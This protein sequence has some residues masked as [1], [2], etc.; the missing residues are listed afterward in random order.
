MLPFVYCVSFFFKNSLIAYS[1]VS[2]F[3]MVMSVVSIIAN[4]LTRIF[5][6]SR[7]VA[8]EGG[9]AEKALRQQNLRFIGNSYD[10]CAK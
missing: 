7:P 9:Y 5:I 2:L 8:K 10:F 3:L 4:L 6:R 1:V